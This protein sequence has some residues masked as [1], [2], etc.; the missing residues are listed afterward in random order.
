MKK[1]VILID[2][3]SKIGEAYVILKKLEKLF[4]VKFSS[5]EKKVFPNKESYQII[6][7]KIYKIFDE[8]IDP[9][10]FQSLEE[11]IKNFYETYKNEFHESFEGIQELSRID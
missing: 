7:S 11:D 1:N 10:D 3:A 6:L 2:Y 8:F 5:D 4:S 9:N